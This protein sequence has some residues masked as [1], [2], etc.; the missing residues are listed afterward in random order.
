[1]IKA[2]IDD[3][4]ILKG[5]GAWSV[6][7]TRLSTVRIPATL[8]GVLQA[9]L[10]TLPPPL[11][12]LL[13]RASV[14]GRIFW[15]AAAVRLSRE[16]AGL[17][18]AE[19]QAMLEDLRDREMILQR[20]ESGFAGTVEYVFRH[21][22]LRDVTY[23]TVIP[24][25]RRALHKIVGDW[26]IEVGGARADEQMLL[27][28]E[29]YSRAEEVALAA[30]QLT[31]VGERAVRLATYDEAST[32]L[33]RARELLTSSEHAE[34]RLEIDLLRGDIEAIRSSYTKAL[35]IFRPALDEARAIGNQHLLA[36]ALGRIGRVIMW[37]QDSTRSLTYL[38][39]AISISRSIGDEATLAF[40]LRQIGNALFQSDSVESIRHLEESAALVR[41][42]GDRQSEASVLN[43]LG[44]SLAVARRMDEARDTYL[45]A[46]D[47]HR[48]IGDRLGEAMALGN[49][50]ALHVD[51]GDLDTAERY[52][53]EALAIIEE[54]GATSLMLETITTQAAIALRRGHDRE[55]HAFLRK[56]SP[57]ARELGLTPSLYPLFHG[58]I[59]IRAGDRKRGLAWIG[60]ARA[61]APSAFETKLYMTWFADLIRGDDSEEE[62]EAAM[63]AGEGLKVEDILAEAE[64]EDS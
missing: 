52:V 62:V 48:A 63:K 5:D 21:A 10:D 34:Q 26:L 4:I 46:L 2:L 30:A 19:V 54:I 31:K 57:A 38:R 13:Q 22:I 28:A 60:F 41:K 42:L 59:R 51:T 55:A 29:H 14:I 16:V 47:V 18:P 37:Q 32:V 3:R 23:E 27:V 7:T 12:Q 56:M 8:T 9:R 61:H 17:E 1:L 6:D 33:Q 24:R 36:N 43:S 15:D 39:E 20:E 45:Q 40:N 11:H 50:G 49:L 35:E 58:I 25:Q 64:R 44:N 53:R